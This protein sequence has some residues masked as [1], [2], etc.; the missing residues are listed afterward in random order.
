[1]NKFVKMDQAPLRAL[2]G[3]WL[4]DHGMEQTPQL[5][6]RSFERVDSIIAYASSGPINNY[7]LS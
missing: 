4:L 1:M 2:E 5:I 6:V 7:A 3:C